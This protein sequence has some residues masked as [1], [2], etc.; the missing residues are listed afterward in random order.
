MPTVL[1]V[2]DDDI[3]RES[4]V[5]LTSAS[6]YAAVGAENGLD[7]LERLR[8]GL[9]PDVILLDLMMP[10]MNGWEFRAEVLK[11]PRFAAI[12]LV[13][14]TG[15]GNEREAAERLG[16]AAALRKPFKPLQILALVARL[17]GNE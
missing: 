10:V 11:E 15:A 3:V 1:V 4:L 13:V 5:E 17:T 12:P 16:A 7:A 14:V 9:V 6:G 2:E 8:A